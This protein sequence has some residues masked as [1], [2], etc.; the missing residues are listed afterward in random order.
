MCS[1]DRQDNFHS[2]LAGLAAAADS[3]GSVDGAQLLSVNYIGPLQCW[4]TVEGSYGTH[5]CWLGALRF[6]RGTKVTSLS[7]AAVAVGKRVGK[8]AVH[9]D[10]VHTWLKTVAKTWF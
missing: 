10:A 5:K 4:E 9:S 8:G 3:L 6:V 1:V 7:T 2:H